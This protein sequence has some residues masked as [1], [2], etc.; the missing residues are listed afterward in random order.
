MAIIDQSVLRPQAVSFRKCCSP[1]MQKEQHLVTAVD[2]K[3]PSAYGGDGVELVRYRRI[4]IP[5]MPDS[6]GR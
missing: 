5:P 2:P 6:F 4:A 3:R 1:W